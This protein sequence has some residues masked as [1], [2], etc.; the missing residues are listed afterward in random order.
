MN[1]Q[2]NESTFRRVY[3]WGDPDFEK[4]LNEHELIFLKSQY[5]IDAASSS[6]ASLAGDI[7]VHIKKKSKLSPALKRSLNSIVGADNVK[8]DDLERALHAAGKFYLDVLK[9]RKGIVENPP[10]AVVY[11][12]SEAEIEKVIALCNA[13]KIPLIPMGARSSVTRALEAFRGG[14]SLDLTKNFNKVL[15]LSVENSSVTVEPGIMGPALEK[16]LNERGYTCGHFPQSFEYSTVGGWAAARG[17]GQASTGYGNMKDMVLGLRVLTPKGLIETSEYPAASIGPDLEQLF[18]GSEGIFGVI[19]S[20]TMKI[21]KYHPD[22]RVMSS[23]I[24]KDFESAVTAMREIMQGQFGQPHFFRLQDPE[25]TDISFAMAGKTDTIADKALKFL[26]YRPASRSLMHAIVEGDADYAKFVMKKIRRVAKSHGA[27]E[28]GTM[29]TRKWLEQRYSSA[30]LRDPMMDAGMII[31]TLETA[32]TWE[33]LTELHRGVREVIKARPDTNCLVHIS[34]CYENGANLYFIFMSPAKSE[35]AGKKSA[36]KNDPQVDD[37]SN[38]QGQII[39]A[40]IKG[41]GSLS[42][43]HGIGRMLSPW[44]ES[45]LGVDGVGIIAAVKKYLDPKNIMNPGG[46]MLGQK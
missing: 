26:G 25:E 9:M 21:R 27:F 46:G 5:G 29:P 35:I 33:N 8:T 22:N 34:H 37:F 2:V 28:T 4:K 14:I 45:E 3:K 18:V 17:A 43:H 13:K 41:G 15:K 39:E 40:I 20:V 44:L 32:V 7:P 10:D 31:D 19:T 24:F 38:F 16:Y 42:H 11:P 36:G 12:G 6:A 1:N 30:Y 23:F